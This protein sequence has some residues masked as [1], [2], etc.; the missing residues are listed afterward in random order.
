[1]TQ[2]S[3]SGFFGRLEP[4]KKFGG[5][6]VEGANASL[7]AKPEQ[8]F[9]VKSIDGIVQ[10]IPGNETGFER[11]RGHLRFSLGLFL[12]GFGEKGPKSG[13]SRLFFLLGVAPARTCP[14][15]Q[16][17]CQGEDFQRRRR[18]PLEE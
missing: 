13:L 8:A 9:P 18:P 3:G 7:A 4:R 14:K 12:R 1:M 16:K 2:S 10:A 15:N 17:Q 5:V 11:I 6:F